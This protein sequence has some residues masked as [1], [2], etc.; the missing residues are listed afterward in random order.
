MRLIRAKW[1]SLEDHY[2]GGDDHK[3]IKCSIWKTRKR[4]TKSY[5]DQYKGINRI[6]V[7]VI[8]TP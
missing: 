2:D 3:M 8:E 4:K 6:L 5:G 1:W 7:L